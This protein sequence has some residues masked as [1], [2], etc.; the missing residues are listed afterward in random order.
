M[1]KGSIKQGAY[2]PL[3]MG[4]LR[5]HQ[6]ASQNRTPIEN[7]Y[8]GGASCHP[9]GLVILG[10]GYVAAHTI[11]EDLGVERPFPEAECVTVA[12][13]EGLL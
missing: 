5:P 12:R 1:A 6:D 11:M 13:Q 4:F 2:H 3:Q 8:V 10:P 9:G 7:L